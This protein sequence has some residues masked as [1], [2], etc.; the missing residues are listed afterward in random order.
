MGLYND[1][2]NE[3]HPDYGIRFDIETLKGVPI[4]ERGR[5]MLNL[6]SS[7]RRE[8][9]KDSGAPWISSLEYKIDG[10]CWAVDVDYWV[11]DLENRLAGL[12]ETTRSPDPLSRV[13]RYLAKELGVPAWV[14]TY[15]EDEEGIVAK[16]HND[17]GGTSIFYGWEA[18]IKTWD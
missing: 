8:T 14:V 10:P 12:L 1:H 18:L 3:D 13:V 16:L 15:R 5:A 2:F 4:N 9:V 6:E 11:M 17:D 7:S